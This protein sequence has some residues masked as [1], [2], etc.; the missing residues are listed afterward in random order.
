MCHEVDV[1]FLDLEKAFAKV[2]HGKQMEKLNIFGKEGLLSHLFKS[3]LTGRLQRVV[4]SGKYSDWL[5]VTSGVPQRSI[6]GACYSLFT[7]MIYQIT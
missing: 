7:S 3:Y 1:T 5:E 6:P 2:F 4:L